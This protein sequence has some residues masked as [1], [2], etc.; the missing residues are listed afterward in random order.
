MLDCRH[1]TLLISRSMEKRLPFRQRMTLRLHLMLCDACT[2]FMRQ[3]HLLRAAI[4][5]LGRKVESDEKLV[6]SKHARE[7]IAEAVA[8]QAWQNDEARRNPSHDSTG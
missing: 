8:I 2:Q 7:R 1:A 3:L 5:R 4:E 6:L